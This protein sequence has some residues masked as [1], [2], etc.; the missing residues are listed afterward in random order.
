MTGNHRKEIIHTY[1]TTNITCKM[2]KDNI[3]LPA[4]K[5]KKLTHIYMYNKHILHVNIHVY[6]YIQYIL[7]YCKLAGPKDLPQ[8]HDWSRDLRSVTRVCMGGLNP[9]E[10]IQRHPH[11]W[12]NVL[13]KH[14]FSFDLQ[15]LSQC[16]IFN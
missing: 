6:I 2:S 3:S 8:G 13:F 10:L 12:N 14:C 15:L 11:T 9:T 4:F 1:A 7:K 16:S 5:I